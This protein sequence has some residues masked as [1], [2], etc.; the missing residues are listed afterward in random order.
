MHHRE[1]PRRTREVVDIFYRLGI[2]K[3][4]SGREEEGAQHVREGA[5][6]SSR[7]HRPTLLAVIDLQTSSRTTGKRHQRQ[8]RRCSPSPT[9]DEK[10]K[11]SRGDGRDLQRQAP[12]LRTKAIASEPRGGGAASPRATSVLHKVLDLYT[13]TE[14][15]KKAI[16]ILGRIATIEKDAAAS[17]GKFF[18]TAGVIYPRC[19]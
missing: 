1:G 2:I 11:L 7:R 8:A 16:E 5:W 19:A 18:Y 14:Q 17:R 10:F 12:E 3:L 13:K 15:W 6:R 9:S 4:R